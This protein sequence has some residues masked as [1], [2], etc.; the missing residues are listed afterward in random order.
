MRPV[1]ARELQ[2]GEPVGRHGRLVAGVPDDPE[3]Q[4]EVVGLVLHD[5]DLRHPYL[6]LVRLGAT[7]AV[8]PA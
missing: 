6:R 3:R 1:L 2:R 7:R 5:E 4:L 8:D